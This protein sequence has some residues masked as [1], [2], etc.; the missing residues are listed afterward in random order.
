[1]PF[2]GMRFTF[3]LCELYGLVM[4]SISELIKWSI[5]LSCITKSPATASHYSGRVGFWPNQYF[6]ESSF[7]PIFTGL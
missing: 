2:A 1:M 5:I 4:S 7:N 6:A 3:P